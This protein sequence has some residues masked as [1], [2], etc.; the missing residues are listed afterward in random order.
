MTGFVHGFSTIS[1]VVQT[2]VTQTQVTP[3]TLGTRHLFKVNNDSNENKNRNDNKIAR[4]KTFDD[5]LER[6]HDETVLVYFQTS[7]CGPC[8]LMKKELDGLQRLLK[9]DDASSDGSSGGGDNATTKPKTTQP[10]PLKIFRLDTER[11]PWLG[12]RFGIQ[13]LPCLVFVKD[14]KVQLKLEGINTATEIAER[15]KRM[16]S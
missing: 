16:N 2:R 13:R 14:H 4:F 9:Q 11:Y 10:L 5:V 12:S 1:V 6:Y 8:R 7:N 15:Y 3:S